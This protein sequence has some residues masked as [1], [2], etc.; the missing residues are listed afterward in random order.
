MLYLWLV[1]LVLV[2][3]VWL[4]LVVFGLPGNWLIV[5]TTC[6]FA[7]WRWED[8]VF[9]IYTLIAIAALA[10]L[11]ELF[12][13][14]AGMIG[15]KK[16]G[17]SWPGSIGALLGAVTGAIVGT[18][19]IPIPF[20]GTLLGA[21][22]GAGLCVWGLEFARGKKAEDSIRYGVGAGLGEFFG[23]TSKFALGIVIWF[24]VAIAAFWP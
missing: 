18:F 20:F 5:I 2:N 1:L 23:I 10:I 13:F 7:W 8:K 17:A 6:L 12:E 14:F 11:G 9:S 15:A 19:L 4:A 22:L 16:S 3:V 21:C 24:I